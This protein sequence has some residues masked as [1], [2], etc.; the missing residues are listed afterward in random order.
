MFDWELLIG[1]MQMAREGRIEKKRA[2]Q[3]VGG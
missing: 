1:A 3:V 2:G